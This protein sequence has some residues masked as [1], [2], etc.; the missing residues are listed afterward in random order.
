MAVMWSK[1]VVWHSILTEKFSVLC[2]ANVIAAVQGGGKLVNS[3]CACALLV[4]AIVLF[5]G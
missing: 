2:G 1:C 5:E 4:S 3:V